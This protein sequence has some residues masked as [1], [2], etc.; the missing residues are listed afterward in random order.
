VGEDIDALI[1]WAE[2]NQWTVRTDAKGYRRFYTPGGDYVVRYPA[3]PS[4]PR[5]RLADGRTALKRNGLEMPPPS[6][7]ERRRRERAN[8]EE[9]T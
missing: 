1:A 5:R 8:R 7:A 2:A 4:N 3:T 9:G 6:K